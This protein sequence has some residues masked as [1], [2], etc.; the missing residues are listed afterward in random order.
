MKEEGPGGDADSGS[1]WGSVEWACLWK[2]GLDLPVE[3]VPG[4]AVRH[5]PK[6][7][8][9]VLPRPR[10]GIQVQPGSAAPPVITRDRGTVG[11]R[12]PRS[13]YSPGNW[14]QAA[15]GVST[16]T[17]LVFQCSSSTTAN[18]TGPSCH[19]K[20][21][22]HKAGSSIAGTLERDRHASS[23][24]HRQVNHTSAATVK[25]YIQRHQSSE[26][27]VGRRFWSWIWLK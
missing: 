26:A 18:V 22:R 4:Q 15:W 5:V 14:M 11:G 13:K 17:C 21:E 3:V 23:A 25:I 24:N 2:C 6:H 12:W 7:R 16:A 10:D 9:C 8:P 20:A 1:A 19:G 27:E